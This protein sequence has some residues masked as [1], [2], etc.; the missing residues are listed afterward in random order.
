MTTPIRDQACLPVARPAGWR[1]AR[2]PRSLAGPPAADRACAD[3]RPRAAGPAP[4][5]P[6]HRS[7]S[8]ARV[9]HRI[10]P[11][12]DREHHLPEDIGNDDHR[13]TPRE[14]EYQPQ[15][16]INAAQRRA[17]DQRRRSC[18]RPASGR[19]ALTRNTT[20]EADRIDPIGGSGTSCARIRASSASAKIADRDGADPGADAQHF[21]H[22]AAHER[23]QAG[24]TRS[25]KTARSTQVMPPPSAPRMARLSSAAAR[26]AKRIDA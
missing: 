22:E 24:D 19:S 11:A 12:F 15:R 10:R 18:R 26:R 6:P 7:A 21:A 1:A 25:P 9:Q 4:S 2:L 3:G 8:G 20:H 23:E 13:R 5:A 16:A 17:A 14:A